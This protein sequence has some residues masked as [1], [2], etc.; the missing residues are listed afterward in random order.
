VTDFEV[1]VDTAAVEEMVA[2]MQQKLSPASLTSFLISK[3]HRELRERAEERF[4]QEGDDVSGP[5]RQLTYATGRIRSFKGFQPFTPINVRTG[6]LKRFV[7]GSFT[8]KQQSRGVTLMMPGPANGDLMSKFRT[9]Q[10][11][12]SKTS[13][14][15]RSAGPNRP[16]PARP[17]LGMNERD[18][19]AIQHELI[20]WIRAGV[21]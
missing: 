17:V 13:R 4:A 3:A 10:Q 20:E 21:F 1:T 15:S 8:V 6:A 5:W 16:T 14:P 19:A 18:S 7:L 2:K 11:G 9:A 12:S